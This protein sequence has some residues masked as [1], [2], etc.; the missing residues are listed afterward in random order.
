MI[1]VMLYQA[2]FSVRCGIAPECSIRVIEIDR[3][4]SFSQCSRVFSFDNILCSLMYRYQCVQL[5]KLVLFDVSKKSTLTG[6]LGECEHSK[7]IVVILTSQRTARVYHFIFKKQ[8]VFKVCVTKQH[9]VPCF[10]MRP[11]AIDV[12]SINNFIISV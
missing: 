3:T 4:S 6:L 5:C 2:H 8:R 12:C 1:D 9:R 11:R 10:I 7:G